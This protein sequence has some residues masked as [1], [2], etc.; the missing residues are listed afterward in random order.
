MFFI[1]SLML[2]LGSAALSTG[3]PPLAASSDQ[4]SHWP[5]FFSFSSTEFFLTLHTQRSGSMALS[6]AGTLSAYARPPAAKAGIVTEKDVAAKVA[7]TASFTAETPGRSKRSTE[8]KSLS[9][10]H[11]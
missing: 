4:W 2:A 7:R 8:T 9:C 6:S 11:P 1:I 10:S 3:L 5:A